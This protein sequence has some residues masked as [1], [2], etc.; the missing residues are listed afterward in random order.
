MMQHMRDEGDMEHD[1]V[2]WDAAPSSGKVPPTELCDPS[3][4]NEDMENTK[5][6]AAEVGVQ[7]AFLQVT[8]VHVCVLYAASSTA[9]VYRQH[10]GHRPAMCASRV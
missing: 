1:A 2:V 8:F 3:D 5:I 9:K 6:D 10:S 7:C 4:L